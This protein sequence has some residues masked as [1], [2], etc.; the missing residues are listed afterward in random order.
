M[1]VLVLA[2]D[3][4][5]TG[6][7]VAAAVVGPESSL[8]EM[9]WAGYGNKRTDKTVLKNFSKAFCQRN[10]PVIVNLIQITLF[11]YRDEHAPSP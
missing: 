1:H 6:N 8:A 7:H 5:Q 11:W 2:E 4:V 3:L 10:G 9:H